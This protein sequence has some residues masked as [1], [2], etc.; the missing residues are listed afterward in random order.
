MKLLDNNFYLIDKDNNIKIKYKIDYG[1][2]NIPLDENFL[3]KYKYI[4]DINDYAYHFSGFYSNN[5]YLYFRFYINNKRTNVFYD[6]KHN[7]LLHGEKLENDI[8]SGSPFFVVGLCEN[9]IIGTVTPYRLLKHFK[10][11]KKNMGEKK[12]RIYLS[13]Y[14]KVEKVLKTVKPQDNQILMLCYLKEK[15]QTKK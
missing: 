3:N 1:K 15:F 9:Y 7:L 6:I 12:W 4:S 5:F 8:D 10:K 2:R 13:K 11:L 14:P